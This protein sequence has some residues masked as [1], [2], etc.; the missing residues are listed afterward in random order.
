MARLGSLCEVPGFRLGLLERLK[1][2]CIVGYVCVC[3]LGKRRKTEEA[4]WGAGL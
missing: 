2:V 4:L 3:V 1:G